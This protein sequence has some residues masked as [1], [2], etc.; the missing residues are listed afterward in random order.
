[1]SEILIEIHA[2][3][4]KKML[5]IMSS[6]EKAAMLSRPQYVKGPFAYIM[7][8]Y[9]GGEVLQHWK[10]KYKTGLIF[11]SLLFIIKKAESIISV[12]HDLIGTANYI[13]AG[14]L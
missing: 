12:I 10:C 6:Y 13:L 9:T 2:F 11:W 7:G 5:L 14:E 3:S 4:F 1:M 8:G